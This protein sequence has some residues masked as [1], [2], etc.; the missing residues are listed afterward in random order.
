MPLLSHTGPDGARRTAVFSS[1]LL[2]TTFLSQAQQLG[3]YV[4]LDYVFPADGRPLAATGELSS[5]SQGAFD[6]QLVHD[7]FVSKSMVE[8]GDSERR[9][10]LRL[11]TSGSGLSQS[12]D[13]TPALQAWLERALTIH[14][15]VIVEAVDTSGREIVGVV[16]HGALADTVTQSHDFSGWP[17]LSYMLSGGASTVDLVASAPG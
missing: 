17:G 16:G 5:R 13:K 11:L 8:T 12:W 15:N 2:A 1:M 6:A 3:H 14:P 10:I 4:K 9:A 7:G